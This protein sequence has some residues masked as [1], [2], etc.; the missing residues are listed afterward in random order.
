M[1]SKNSDLKQRKKTASGIA[2]EDPDL[3]ISGDRLCPLL[4]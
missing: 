3:T 4:V 2:Y 1:A